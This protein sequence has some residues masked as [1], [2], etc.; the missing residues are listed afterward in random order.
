MPR[1]FI[2]DIDGCLAEPFQPYDL[3]KWQRLAEHARRAEANPDAGPRI[4]LCSGRA[5]AYV[6]AVTQA[7]G[8]R[9]PSLFESGAGAFY[10]ETAEVLWNPHLTP[11]V[12]R[13]L[14]SVKTWMFDALLPASGN[15]R[16]DYGK[17]GQTGV[18]GL[19][20]TDIEP[21]VPQVEAYVAAHF[22]ERFRVFHTH[23]SIDV[24]PTAITKAAAIRWM[25]AHEGYALADI[26]YIGDT[27]GDIEA[28][29][30]VGHA[31]AP[32]NATDAVKAVA[33]HVTTASHI[34][35][36]LEALAYAK[37]PAD[38]GRLTTDHR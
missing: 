35:G 18:V 14:A 5:Y 31:F 36:V 27:N 8:L 12:E 13:D 25:A 38:H 21:L 30:C 26:A 16:F 11:D 33:N 10:C 3:P 28:L 9:T 32:S 19:D 1:L 37:A 6:E 17:R 24:V 20:W 2:C 29:E 4:S 23:V 22:P 15:V 7:L 34:D